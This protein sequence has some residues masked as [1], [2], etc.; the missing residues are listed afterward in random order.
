MI[1][2][3]ITFWILPKDMTEN[4]TGN[5]TK[6]ITEN[7]TENIKAENIIIE[8]FPSYFCFFDLSAEK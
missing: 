6:N 8:G 4:V 3:N 7:I 5:V 2:E 1:T